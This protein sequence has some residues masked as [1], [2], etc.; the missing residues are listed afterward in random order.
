M[1][2]LVDITVI[3]S[4]LWT[5]LEGGGSRF[6]HLP[7]YMVSCHKTTLLIFSVREFQIIHMLNVPFFLKE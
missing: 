2:W 3:I 5:C 7:N 6:Y 1:L 4:R